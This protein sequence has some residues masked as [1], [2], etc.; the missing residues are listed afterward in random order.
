MGFLLNIKN[1]GTQAKVM[2]WCSI[3][4]T[5]VRR[6]YTFLKGKNWR[7]ITVRYGPLVLFLGRIL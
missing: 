5:D 1:P 6:Y 3:Q 4:I 7:F 2:S